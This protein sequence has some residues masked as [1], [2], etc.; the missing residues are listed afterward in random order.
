MILAD[1]DIEFQRR[2]GGIG[3]SPYDPGR[4]QPASYDVTLGPY[5][6]FIDQ[7]NGPWVEKFDE[8]GLHYWLNRDEFVLLSTIE[9]ITLDSH[10]AAQVAGK[11]TLARMGLIVESAGFIDPGFS[12][13]LTLEVKNI[14]PNPILL[15][16]G[17]P[18]AQVV[19]FQMVS[20]AH[21]PYNKERNHYQ[22][23]VGPVPARPY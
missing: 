16:A 18:I 17:M 4:L 2:I 22:N 7:P 23:Q 13:Q 19:F 6:L 20:K 8:P 3:I 21:N 11:S 14:G 1:V 5:A 12:G 15:T 10:H 9:T